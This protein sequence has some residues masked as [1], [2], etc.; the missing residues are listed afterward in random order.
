DPSWTRVTRYSRAWTGYR[1]HVLASLTS[2]RPSPPPS[3]TSLPVTLPARSACWATPGP[4][5]GAIIT[6]RAERFGHFY[7]L[8]RARQRR[9]YERHRLRR[10]GWYRMLN[11]GCD[12]AQF[13]AMLAAQGCLCPICRRRPGGAHL[14]GQILLDCLQSQGALRSAKEDQL[15]DP[16]RGDDPVPGRTLQPLVVTGAPGGLTPSRATPPR[17]RHAWISTQGAP[18]TRL[19]AR[20]GSRSGSLP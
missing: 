9:Y 14:M 5:S 11:Y 19:R 20:Q 3:L 18:F 7:D 6:K 17:C 4:R 15:L 8:K 12:P 1:R 2:G 10:L 13:D 16:R